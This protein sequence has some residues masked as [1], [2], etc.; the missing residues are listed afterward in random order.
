MNA[1]SLPL[2]YSDIVAAPGLEIVLNEETSRH[3][4]QVLRMQAGERIELTDGEGMCILAELTVSHKRNSV[5]RVLES[6]IAEQ[7]KRK[8]II[9]ISPLKNTGRFEWFLEKATELGIYAIQ[10]LICKRTEKTY[11]RAER[12]RSIIVSAMLQSRQYFLPQLLEPIKPDQL[13]IDS[14]S[15]CLIAHCGEGEKQLLSSV[16]L[17]ESGLIYILIGPEGD[18]TEEETE[19]LIGK[20]FQPVSLGTTRL[21]TETAGVVS[22]AL[23]A[24]SS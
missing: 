15:Y 8:I 1:S 11:F 3:L 20:G 12:F 21:R 7:L 18:F 24:L 6:R 5:V 4:S 17:P 10:P 14:A 16:V 2:F 23:L 22:A 19:I 13:K 9:G